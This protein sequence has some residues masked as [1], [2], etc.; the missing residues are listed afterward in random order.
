[1]YTLDGSKPTLSS[2][3]YASAGVREGAET[4]TVPS[5]TRINWFS[6]DAAGNVEKNYQ[7]DGNNGSNYNRTT[8]N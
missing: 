8:V 6:V 2:T 5:G 7:P 4:L 3:M 1:F